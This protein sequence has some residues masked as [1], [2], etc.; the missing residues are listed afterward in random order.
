MGIDE[1]LKREIVDDITEQAP[2][3]RQWLRKYLEENWDDIISSLLNGDWRKYGFRGIEVREA[4]LKSGAAKEDLFTGRL[5]VLGGRFYTELPD[6]PLGDR[7]Y[8]FDHPVVIRGEKLSHPRSYMQV[9]EAP[10]GFEWKSVFN[11]KEWL[12]VPGPVR[13]MSEEEYKKLLEQSGVGW[14]Y[15][16]AAES[17]RQT[18]EAMKAAEEAMKATEEAMKS[19]EEAD[20]LAKEEEALAQICR[21]WTSPQA[22]DITIL[23][24]WYVDSS[25]GDVTV[26]KPGARIIGKLR[27]GRFPRGEGFPFVEGARVSALILSYN[28]DTSVRTPHQTFLLGSRKKLV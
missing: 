24:D 3:D 28:K 25:V 4:L 21:K 14:D 15:V 8:S 20:R 19:A 6:L 12:E 23:D 10:P 17:F 7:T 9:I 22:H 11:R 16:Q 27:T 18:K 5:I 2:E 26:P 13:T 1:T